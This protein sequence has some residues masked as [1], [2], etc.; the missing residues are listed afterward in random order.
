MKTEQ[1][2]LVELSAL[3]SRGEHCLYEMQT[4]LQRWGIIGEAQQRI[5]NYLVDERYV[6]DERFC[7]AFVRDKLTYNGW[8]RR[9]I[10]QALWM[11]RI[12]KAVSK[13][14]LDDI[15]DNQWEERLM[16]LLAAKRKTVKTESDYEMNQKLF[17]FA[18]GRGFT[19]DIV[20][21]CLDADVDIDDT[22]V[23][24]DE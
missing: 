23:D 9:K 7:K 18:L 12:P 19:Y 14:V 4:K 21:R 15:E 24:F 5:L 13:A 8:G 16:P 20:R 22:D 17:R 2:A 1:Q 6:D 10:E 3:C 11:K